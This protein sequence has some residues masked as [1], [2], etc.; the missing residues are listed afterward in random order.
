[1]VARQSAERVF[2]V[3][4]VL[5]RRLGA[6]VASGMGFR[7]SQVLTHLTRLMGDG[8]VCGFG[9]F[10]NG[11]EASKGLVLGGGFFGSGCGV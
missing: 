11:A 5:H 3:G 7:R 1:M 2:R 4:L 10:E 6:C 9:E 8:S